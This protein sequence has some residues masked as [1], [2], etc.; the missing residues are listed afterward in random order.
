MTY[1]QPEITLVAN[2]LSAVEFTSKPNGSC[3]SVPN[4]TQPSTGC[5]EIEE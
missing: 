2:A 1:T 5:Y 3:D 4:S